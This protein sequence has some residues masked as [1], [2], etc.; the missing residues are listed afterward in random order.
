MN[1][2]IDAKVSRIYEVNI[3]HL[4]NVS[5]SKNNAETIKSIIG[6]SNGCHSIKTGILSAIEENNIYVANILFRSLIEHYTKAL[7][8]IYRFSK[9]KNNDVGKDNLIFAKA[10]EIKSY[11]N[12]LKL[13]K[14]LLNEDDST[15]NYST[16]IEKF[17]AE[18]AD[19]SSTELKD[20]SNQ[21]KYRNIIKFC[22]C[23]A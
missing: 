21:F 20:A 22:N 12:A 6:L 13:Y 2:D 1:L 15:V 11:G 3:P 5:D 8:V 16:A 18:A 7:F 4:A 9:E 17:S 10:H 23:S 14:S 19:K